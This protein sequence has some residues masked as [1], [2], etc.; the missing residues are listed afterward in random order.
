MLELSA[1]AASDTQVLLSVLGRSEES[2]PYLIAVSAAVS[3]MHGNHDNSA[4][5][6]CLLEGHVMT[7]TSTTVMLIL[8]PSHK[9]LRLDCI[10]RL[11]TSLERLL[12]AT[13]NHSRQAQSQ[14][15]EAAAL[16]FDHVTHHVT[17]ALDAMG[18][19]DVIAKSDRRDRLA[20]IPTTP[21]RSPSTCS[22]HRSPSPSMIT[23][24]PHAMPLLSER[25][26]SI[27]PKRKA[28]NDQDGRTSPN[29]SARTLRELRAAHE[30]LTL[31]LRKVEE[32][33]AWYREE[34]DRWSIKRMEFIADL[35]GGAAIVT[36]DVADHSQQPT[37][38]LAA[39]PGAP[40]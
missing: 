36:P 29:L 11:C 33:V 1:V 6:D 23:S 37:M 17:V 24:K 15:A 14:A 21:S 27:S 34:A 7:S 20:L 9:F 40:Q 19:A 5:Q 38:E 26:P 31:H 22:H 2:T 35:R 32:E 4:L 13:E 30:A 25:L 12:P 18:G 28:Q 39:P 8:Q 16:A 10:G 3:P